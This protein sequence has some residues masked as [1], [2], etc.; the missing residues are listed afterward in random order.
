MLTEEVHKQKVSKLVTLNLI[1]CLEVPKNMNYRES[2]FAQS[3]RQ[4]TSNMPV[5]LSFT[6]ILVSTLKL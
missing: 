4:I 3:F 1:E 5:P 6:H 2:T